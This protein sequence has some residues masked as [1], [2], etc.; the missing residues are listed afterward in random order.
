MFGD[1]PDAAACL[2]DIKRAIIS[3]GVD[4]RL[5]PPSGDNA[6]VRIRTAEFDA[7]HVFVVAHLSPGAF[8]DKTAGRAAVDDIL[9][10]VVGA[11]IIRLVRLLARTEI[12][13]AS[14]DRRIEGRS[15]TN[16]R[17]LAVLAE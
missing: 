17:G 15:Q 13:E 8:P 6:G 16:R 1:T 2:L 10:G 12:A 3:G 5:I 4:E 9:I 7:S 11:Q 14:G